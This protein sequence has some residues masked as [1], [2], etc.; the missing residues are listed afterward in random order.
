MGSILRPRYHVQESKFNRF[1]FDGETYVRC[2]SQGKFKE[3]CSETT[4][5]GGG[6]LVAAAQV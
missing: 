3:R 4:V 1:V 2:H 6:G 5:K